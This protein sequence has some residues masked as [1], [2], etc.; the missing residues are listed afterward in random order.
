MSSAIKLLD[1]SQT[2]AFDTEYVNDNLFP[3]VQNSIRQQNLYK[4]PIHILDIGGG[5]GLFADKLL[6]H[7]PFSEVTIVEPD[8][9]LLAR[10]TAHCHKHLVNKTFQDFYCAE[11]SFDIIHM[12]WVLHHFIGHSY[13]ETVQHQIDSLHQASELLKPGGK[14]LIFENFYESFVSDD[15]SGRLIYQLT[16]METPKRLIRKLGANT[17]GIGVA[18]HSQNQWCHLINRSGLTVNSV[19]LCYSFGNLGLTKKAALGISDQ[20]VG[21]VVCS[22][23]T[24]KH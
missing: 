15:F 3:L 13:S 7:F 20:Q 12:N 14:L 10:N 8:L 23:N 19:N 21:F 16:A 1:A 22:P 5:N 11:G 4:S 17:A 18:F 2:E 24:A 6:K 9:P